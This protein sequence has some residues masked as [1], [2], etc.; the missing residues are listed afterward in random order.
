MAIVGTAVIAVLTETDITGVTTSGR[1]TEVQG[2]PSPV[3]TDWSAPAPLTI[4]RDGDG[5]PIE[6]NLSAALVAAAGLLDGQT[7]AVRVA[8]D[9]TDGGPLIRTVE[10]ELRR[11]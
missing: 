3:V 11:G 2:E 4:D 9:V 1:I 10:Y 8:L 5:R 7:T 6:P